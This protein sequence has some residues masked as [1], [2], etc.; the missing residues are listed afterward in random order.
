MRNGL[1]LFA[2]AVALGGHVIYGFR[3]A[4]RDLGRLHADSAKCR[5][6]GWGVKSCVS[7]CSMVGKLRSWE[8]RRFIRR[9]RDLPAGGHLRSGVYL[10]GRS[11]RRI[12]QALVV[13][14]PL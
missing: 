6:V 12:T 2:T 1:I 13:R 9:D 10:A 3:R 11:N 5:L 4:R 8:L 7:L 14:R